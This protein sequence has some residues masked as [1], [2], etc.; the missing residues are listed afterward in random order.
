MARRHA[1]FPLVGLHLGGRFAERVPPDVRQS[2]ADERHQQGLRNLLLT[3]EL[4]QLS[5]LFA[6]TGIGAIWFKGPTLALTAYRD[7]SLRMFGDLDVLV[8][9]IG[10]QPAKDLLQGRGY[11][12][13][14]KLTADQQIDHLRTIG[15]LPMVAEPG[16]RVVELHTSLAPRGFNFAPDMNELWSRRRELDVQAHPVPVLAAEDLLLFLCVHGAKHLWRCLG[17]VC[18]VAE[19]LRSQPQLNWDRLGSRAETWYCR[20][21]FWLGLLL[22]AETLNAP[23]PDQVLAR[24]RRCRP[25]RTLAQRVSDAWFRD[26]LLPP[27]GWEISWFHMRARERLQDALSY[28]ASLALTPTVAD[29]QSVHLAKRLNLLYYLVRP[30]R[31]LGKYGSDQMRGGRRT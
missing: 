16:R 7:L 1:I 29:W 21:M 22:A 25:V 30:L 23:C 20:R 17:W 12:S 11:R 4:V 27:S 15:Q 6:Q 18:D 2:I 10:L 8:R 14:E 24:A 5:R 3:G 31:L 28:A 9:P 13:A 19:L 26:E